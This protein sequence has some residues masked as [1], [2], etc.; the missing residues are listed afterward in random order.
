M[1]V[2]NVGEWKI[3]VTEPYP[4][5]VT[6]HR[7]DVFIRSFRHDELRDLEYAVKRAIYAAS[8]M[9]GARKSEMD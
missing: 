3:E 8:E 9:L 2:I 7:R 5:W 1:R 6:I 4:C